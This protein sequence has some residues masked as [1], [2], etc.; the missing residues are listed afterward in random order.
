MK[1]SHHLITYSVWMMA[2]KGLQFNTVIS[3]YRIWSNTSRGYCAKFEIEGG[4][5]LLLKSSPHLCYDVTMLFIGR[6]QSDRFVID[7]LYL[8]PVCNRSNAVLVSQCP[9]I[10]YLL[11]IWEKNHNYYRFSAVSVVKN[12]HYWTACSFDF[13]NILLYIA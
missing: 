5:L 4:L 6:P 10:T 11:N 2:T 7:A 12:V 13:I 8:I 9:S 3:I 1:I